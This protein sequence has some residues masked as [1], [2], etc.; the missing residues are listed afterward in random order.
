[1]MLSLIILLFASRYVMSTST[2]SQRYQYLLTSSID[3]SKA[4]S[5]V[6]TKKYRKKMHLKQNQRLPQAS[7]AVSNLSG[8]RQ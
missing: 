1:V 7:A 8:L 2:V 4:L 5:G 6:L 3:F